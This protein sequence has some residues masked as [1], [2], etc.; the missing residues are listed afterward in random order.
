MYIPTFT[1]WGC[2]A[3]LV[4]EDG[5][6]IR[7]IA[8]VPVTLK[9]VFVPS[10]SISMEDEPM[11]WTVKSSHDPDARYFVSTKGDDKPTVGLDPRPALHEDYQDDTEQEKEAA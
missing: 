11:L 10:A 9:D 1:K 8:S 7:A 6:I 2:P 5:K 4:V 3:S